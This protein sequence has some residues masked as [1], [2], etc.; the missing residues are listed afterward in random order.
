LRQL[1]GLDFGRVEPVAESPLNHD[2][3][4]QERG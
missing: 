2:L 4:L 3:F 1:L